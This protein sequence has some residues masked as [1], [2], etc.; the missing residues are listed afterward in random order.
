M[1]QDGGRQGG[2][3]TF[4]VYTE[5][6]LWDPGTPVSPDVVVGVV[7]TGVVVLDGKPHP[8]IERNL[9]PGWEKHADVLPR[10]GEQL[11]RYD[12]HG[13]FVAGLI[14]AKASAATI[15]IR[16]GLDLSDGENVDAKVA[17]CIRELAAVEHLR[18]VNLSF[19]STSGA[20]Y[21]EPAELKS[22]LDELFRCNSDV[23]VVAAVA[24][25]WT[26]DKNWP[27]AFTEDFERVIAVGA[28]DESVTPVPGL[29]PP[30]ASFCSWWDGVD[31]FASGC[32]V[33]GP[34][35]G[36]VEVPL[37]SMDTLLRPWAAERINGAGT[38]RLLTQ[39]V[40]RDQFAF[41]TWS[42]ASFAAA[43]VSGL[44]AQAMLGGA[45]SG[46]AAIEQVIHS[47]LPRIPLPGWPD[48]KP[49]ILDTWPV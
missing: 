12:G 48:G 18:V 30:R 2:A 15:D 31:V 6:R 40:E 23:V 42:G 26:A 39:L 33:I 19:F 45:S 16:R 25:R 29:M 35:V 3:A 20:E 32:G 36:R 9:A 4:Q 28:L 37:E 49:A 38:L 27:A 7:D 13:T 47:S 11:G 44:L 5:N 14:K 10:S 24:N 43:K 22:A 46:R 21:Q 8:Y 17:A 1:T 41:S 34:S